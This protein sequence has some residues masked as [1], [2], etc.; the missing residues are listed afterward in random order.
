MLPHK[1][2]QRLALLLLV[3]VAAAGCN[4]FTFVKPSM[5][6]GKE[7]ATR[8][9]VVAR[10]NAQVRA[11]MSAQD[12]IIAASVALQNGDLAEA[13]SMARAALKTDANS[14]D[15]HTLMGLVAERTGRSTDAGNWL[16]KAAELSAGRGPEM[17]NYGS[18]LCG[19]GRAEESLQY[20]EHAVRTL[21]SQG[22]A[23]TLANAGACAMQAGDNTRADGYLR[24]AIELD[25]KNPLALEKM[26]ELALR[27]RQLLAARAFIERRLA[28]RPITA[29]QLEL[30]SLIEAQIG[31]A[32]AA[33]AYRQRR[34]REFPETSGSSNSGQ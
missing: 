24:R 15:A 25:E 6:R 12:Q 1:S 26:A 11:R 9:P 19:H 13:E 20:F 32:R 31:D 17:S 30:A 10:D 29:D 28:L 16:K 4:R 21:G 34:L 18:W 23:D 8:P 3:L 14:V 5:K 7:V 22:Q 27:Q 2:V 33:A